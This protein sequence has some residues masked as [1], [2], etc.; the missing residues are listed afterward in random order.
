MRI[1]ISLYGIYIE[2][3]EHL[4]VPNFRIR[5]IILYSE[6]LRL[7]IGRFGVYTVEL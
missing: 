7:D 4:E 2:G 5:Y 3:D 1:L 6:I